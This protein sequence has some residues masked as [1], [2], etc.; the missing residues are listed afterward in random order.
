[1]PKFTSDIL[2]NFGHTV[3]PDRQFL[4]GQK[5]VENAKSS[6]NSNATFW[7]IFK[8]CARW[9][10]WIWY[11]FPLWSEKKFP[12]LNH[13]SW[14]GKEQNLLTFC[15]YFSKVKGGSQGKDPIDLVR[16][17]EHV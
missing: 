4:I 15:G 14:R 6:K 10:F 16:V 8:Q 11:F 17:K 2:S 12:L 9:G 5:L 1:M 3:L 13:N 7:V